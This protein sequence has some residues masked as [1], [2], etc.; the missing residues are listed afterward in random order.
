MRILGLHIV[1]CKR[2][3]AHADAIVDALE[4]HEDKLRKFGSVASIDTG[5]ALHA[6][7]K[8]AADEMG[9]TVR[10]LSGGVKPPRPA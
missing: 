2:A 6:A 10:P 7:L 5:Q 4:A 9:V 1:T 3:K 8:A